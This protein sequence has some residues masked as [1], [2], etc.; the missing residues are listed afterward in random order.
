MITLGKSMHRYERE[1]A[2]F[3]YIKFMKRPYVI[4]KGDTLS[5]IAKREFGSASLWPLLWLKNQIMLHREQQ[6]LGRIMRHMKGPDWI[7]PG[8]TIDLDLSPTAV[9]RA[10]AGASSEEIEG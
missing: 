5:S 10:K 7:F 6:L 1:Y 9:T 2:Q 3:H 8:T 4:Q